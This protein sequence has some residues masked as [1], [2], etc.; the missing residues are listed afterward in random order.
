MIRLVFVHGWSVTNTNTYGFLPQAISQQ[1]EKFGL[2]IDISHVFIGR[3]ISF[4]DQVSMRDV[5]LAFDRALRV[6]LAT[7]SGDLPS[8][9]CITHSTGG[10]VVRE[11]QHVMYGPDPKIV[12]PLTH[13]IMLAPANHGSA[14]A[15]LG[16]ARVGRIRAWFQ[17]MEPGQRILDW[18]CLGSDAQ[19]QLN[20]AFLRQAQAERVGYPFV[21]TGQSI[22]KKFYDFINAYLKEAGSDG[23]VRV[24]AANL[25]CGYVLLT[26]NENLVRKRPQVFEL[27]AEQTLRVHDVPLAVI[28][29]TAHSG[30][31]MGIMASVS[32]GNFR[33]KPIVNQIMC[34]LTVDSRESYQR[35]TKKLSEFTESTQLI[36]LKAAMLVFQV[37]DDHGQRI[38]DFDLLLLAGRH[39]QAN[40]LP[41]GF[42]IDKQK[43]ESTGRIVFFVN[44]ALLTPGCSL[45]VKVVARPD[46]GFSYYAPAEFRSQGFVL[47]QHIRANQTLYLEIRLQRRIAKNVFRLDPVTAGSHDFRKEPPLF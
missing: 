4:H 12:C 27:K 6:T 22:D 19:W 25:N 2:S 8:F 46:R 41:S 17:G 15:A 14:L 7:E 30:A 34:C 39:Y 47:A 11:W 32:A 16:K 3:Y 5:V 42:V 20:L 10:P 43:N 9:S 18:L 45:G 24:A 26:Q 1:A 35:Q 44:V 21:L 13:L 37:C 38:K 29:D 33:N 28:P 31:S 36:G 23:V 40:A